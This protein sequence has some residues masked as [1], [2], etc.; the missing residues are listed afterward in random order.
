MTAKLDRL[1]LGVAYGGLRSVPRLM[2][3]MPSRS[4]RLALRVALAP[5]HK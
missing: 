4:A 5:E 1:F 2:P 3:Q